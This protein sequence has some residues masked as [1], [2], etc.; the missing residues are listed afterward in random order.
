MENNS[1]K[2]KKGNQEELS[3]NVSNLK[4]KFVQKV[5]MQVNARTLYHIAEKKTVIKYSKLPNGQNGE[6]EPKTNTLH[7]SKQIS[8]IDEFKRVIVHESGHMFDSKD[9]KNLATEVIK[10]MIKTDP[11]LNSTGASMDKLLKE[12]GTRQLSS[13]L[14]N[15]LINTIN[16][17]MQKAFNINISI[18]KLGDSPFIAMGIKNHIMDNY[19]QTDV[20][21]LYALES[22]EEFFA[23]AYSL[24]VSGNC[25]SAELLLTYFPE[26]LKLIKQIIE[27]SE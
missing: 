26:S 21:K 19:M 5:L 16:M 18:P 27:S 25:K 9:D 12:Y 1:L 10:D 6:Y 13:R 8:N 22:V 7:L 14:N 11:K 4:Q 24:I 3:I 20:N 17:E 23:E 15:E 2:I